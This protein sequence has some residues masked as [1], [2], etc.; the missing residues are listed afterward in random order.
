MAKKEAAPDVKKMLDADIDE[1]RKKAMVVEKELAM[2]V[3]KIKEFLEHVQAKIEDS[4]VSVDINKKGEVEIEFAIKALL[5]K[6]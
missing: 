4:K 3:G 6:K 2:D 5:K 1:I